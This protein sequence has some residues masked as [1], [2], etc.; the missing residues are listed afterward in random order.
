MSKTAKKFLILRALSD[1]W[2]SG[3]VANGYTKRDRTIR[4][5]CQKLLRDLEEAEKEVEK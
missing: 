3:F 1:A 2:T 5:L 4:Y